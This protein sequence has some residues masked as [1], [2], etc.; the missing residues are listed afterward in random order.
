M[1]LDIGQ[2]VLQQRCSTVV[3]KHL[4]RILS[5]IRDNF[6]ISNSCNSITSVSPSRVFYVYCIIGPSTCP[7]KDCLLVCSDTAVTVFFLVC[8]LSF[9]QIIFSD[10]HFVSLSDS[11]RIPHFLHS[12][13]T[14][15]C[16]CIYSEETLKLKLFTCPN[17]SCKS[18]LL[19]YVTVKN[20]HTLKS[21]DFSVGV[22]LYVSTSL[23]ISRITFLQ[24]QIT[25]VAN[26]YICLF[27]NFPF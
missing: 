9:N 6:I 7:H 23:Y 21:Y 14:Q 17:N 26:Q 15:K 19:F 1:Q 25:V 12:K 3:S 8:L 2:M 13:V 18:H 24:S 11:S 10:Q 27:P 16:L 22:K 5:I 20:V 4:G